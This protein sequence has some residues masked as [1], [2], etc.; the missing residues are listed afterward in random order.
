MFICKLL[1]CFIDVFL[2]RIKH[3]LLTSRIL[4]V[5]VEILK[6]IVVLLVTRKVKLKQTLSRKAFL[7]IEILVA[8]NTVLTMVS[9]DWSY[10]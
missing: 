1:H 10:I 5:V 8:C 4:I 9:L 2:I 7:N 6:F 3:G